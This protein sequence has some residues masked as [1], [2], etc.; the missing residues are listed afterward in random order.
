MGPNPKLE[1]KTAEST[2]VTVAPEWRVLQAAHGA[3]QRSGEESARHMRTFRKFF[4][5]VDA[6][7]KTRLRVEKSTVQV[8]GGKGC[9]SEVNLGPAVDKVVEVYCCL[10]FNR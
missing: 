7:S 3:K 6:R 4:K 8:G 2:A 10:T 9:K 1:E 5:D